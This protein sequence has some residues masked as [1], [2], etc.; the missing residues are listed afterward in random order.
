MFEEEDEEFDSN[1]GD[2]TW[3]VH[4]DICRSSVR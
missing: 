1:T 4:V 2:S 3:E